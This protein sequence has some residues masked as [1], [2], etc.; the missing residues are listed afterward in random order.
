MI[1]GG[2]SRKQEPNH[3]RTYRVVFVFGSD[4]AEDRIPESDIVIA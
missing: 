4:I 1:L 3:R 2:Y